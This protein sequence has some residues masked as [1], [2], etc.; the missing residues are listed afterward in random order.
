MKSGCKRIGYHSAINVSIDRNGY[1]VLICKGRTKPLLA[2]S[3]LAS[4]RA[5]V[6]FLGCKYGSF[7]QDED[8]FFVCFFFFCKMD[9][10]VWFLVDPSSFENEA[11]GHAASTLE[12]TDLCK[13]S[14]QVLSQNSM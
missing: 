4:V 1:V 11:D 13:A 14:D 7:A 2:L 9:I 5:L 3:A 12:P 6:G 8:D 10:A